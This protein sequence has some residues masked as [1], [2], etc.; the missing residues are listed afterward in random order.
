MPLLDVADSVLV[1]IDAQP[2][3]YS[4]E[5]E[6]DRSGFD[7]ARARIAWL[8]GVA[9]ALDVPAIVTEEDPR[10]NGPTDAAVIAALPDATPVFEKVVF[11]LAAVP[12]ILAAVEATGR[13]TVV[14]CGIETDVCVAHSAIGLQDRGLRVAVVVDATFS[15]GEAHEHGLRRLADLGIERLSAKSLFYDWVGTL[16]RARA[17]E[18]THPTL[19]EPPGFSL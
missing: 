3:F 10:R 7:A 13:R 16:E 6:V 5:R 2:G 1:V 8:A 14:L 18:A 11:G 4:S 19:A 15:P 9:R 12:E 17:I